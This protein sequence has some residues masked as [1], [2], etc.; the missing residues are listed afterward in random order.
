[1]PVVQ[2]VATSLPGHVLPQAALRDLA[3]QVLPDS[4]GKPGILEVFNRD[5]LPPI[6]ERI[7]S[8]GR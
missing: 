1:M 3:D 4:P 8:L 2:A 5:F 6:N 7:T